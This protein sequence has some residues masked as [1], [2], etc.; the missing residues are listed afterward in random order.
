MTAASSLA[1]SSGVS[2]CT[3]WPRCSS[4]SLAI[5][6]SI[7]CPTTMPTSPLAGS[8]SLSTARS[9]LVVPYKGTRCLGVGTARPR[10]GEALTSVCAQHHVFVR[11]PTGLSPTA[12]GHQLRGCVT[13][14]LGES[15]F[16]L[17]DVHT[18]TVFGER[19]CD[20]VRRVRRW[21]AGG[22]ECFDEP[23]AS[24]GVLYLHVEPCRRE[25]CRQSS[26]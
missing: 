2:T 23:G 11:I 21:L 26:R 7:L 24:D 12:V 22:V 17:V 6:L 8:S 1:A 5:S 15:G 3:M 14:L 16:Q 13:D 4:G 10:G 18:D 25:P 20:G 9:P 19:E